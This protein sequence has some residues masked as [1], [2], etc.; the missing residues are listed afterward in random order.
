MDLVV[1]TRSEKME[2][3]REMEEGK[4]AFSDLELTLQI[5]EREPR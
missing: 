1:K 4:R 5:L 3:Q 2:I